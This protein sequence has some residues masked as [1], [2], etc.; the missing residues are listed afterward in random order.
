[1]DLI[2]FLVA[3]HPKEWRQRYGEE[4]AALLEDNQLT[5]SAAVNVAAHAARLRIRAHLEGTL[6]AVALANRADRQ[7]PV[8]T[9]QRPADTR[10][11]RHGLALGRADHQDPCVPP[12][13]GRGLTPCI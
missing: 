5:P 9:H 2:R 7:H 1:M 4:F 6:V 3:L 13:R 12:L 11:P 8:G 10:P